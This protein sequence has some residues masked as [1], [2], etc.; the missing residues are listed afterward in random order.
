MWYNSF[1]DDQHKG[2]RQ[3]YHVKTDKRSQTSA[4]LI[5][6][7]LLE[8]MKKKDFTQITIT[9]IQRASGVGRSTFYRLFDNVADVLAYMCD[10]QFEKIICDFNELPIITTDEFLL[11]NIKSW[12]ESIDLIKALYSSDR[13]DLLFRA[14]RSSINKVRDIFVTEFGVRDDLNFSESELDYGLAGLLCAMMGV[15]GVWADRGRKETPEELLRIIKL[16]FDRISN[17]AM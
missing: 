10:K 2:V 6:E 12:M 4:R 17:I 3:M 7:G 9:D 8:C 11:L 15:L 1:I 14:S 16:A 5:S 13:L